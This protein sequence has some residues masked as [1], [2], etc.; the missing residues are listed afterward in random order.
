MKLAAKLSE[1]MLIKRINR[2]LGLIE[3]GENLEYCHIRD[4]GRLTEL[5]VPGVKILVKA[6]N[7]KGRK[8][9]FELIS[10]YN[11]GLNVVVNSGLHSKLAEEVLQTKIIPEL[12]GYRVEASEW[13]FGSGR[14]DFLLSDGH[15]EYLLEIKGC[16][17]VEE[18]FALFPDAPTKR[19]QKHLKE[20][21][22]SL[23]KG[24]KA[25]ILFLVMRKDA[26]S[27]LVNSETD[28]DFGY[29]FRKAIDAGV[30]AFAY[31]FDFDGANIKPFKRISIDL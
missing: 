2:F 29:L 9:R 21:I 12:A 22:V 11:S 15:E 3:I 4:P 25:G 14:I 19:G 13:R 6:V 18:G 28:P 30:Q 5:L 26:K 23:Q 31:S 16:T 17:L 7:K 8:T 27:F 1:A 24:F 10:V 20:L